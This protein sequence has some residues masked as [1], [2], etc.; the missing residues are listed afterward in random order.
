MQLIQQLSLFFQITDVSA[1]SAFQVPPASSR[2]PEDSCHQQIKYQIE[3][4]MKMLNAG[5]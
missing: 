4:I 5:Q 3:I 2:T 1:V